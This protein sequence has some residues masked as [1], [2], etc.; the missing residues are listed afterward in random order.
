MF[1]F[2]I[3]VYDAK[4]QQKT[5]NSQIKTFILCHFNKL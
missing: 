4:V 3:D 2:V 1:L 5:F